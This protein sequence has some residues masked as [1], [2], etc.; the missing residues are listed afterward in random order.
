MQSRQDLAGP[1]RPLDVAGGP[2]DGDLSNSRLACIHHQLGGGDGR[3][4]AFN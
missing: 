3:A 4:G 1:W 2:G